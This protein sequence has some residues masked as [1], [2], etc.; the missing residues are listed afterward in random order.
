MEQQVSEYAR[1]MA[2]LTTAR[3]SQCPDF[4]DDWRLPPFWTCVGCSLALPI[5]WKTSCMHSK[6]IMHKRELQCIAT[7]VVQEPS[8]SPDL[9]IVQDCTKQFA[10]AISVDK[11]RALV[12]YQP[13]NFS[14]ICFISEVSLL[15]LLRSG[16]KVEP[17]PER[18]CFDC[19]CSPNAPHD[20]LNFVLPVHS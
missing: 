15:A 16:S 12:A 20:F 3:R 2:D 19:V 7:E 13:Q 17:T 8:S 1:V 18:C 5:A 9:L 14:L 4:H 6:R 11:L 10:L